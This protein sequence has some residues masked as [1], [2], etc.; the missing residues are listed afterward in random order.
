MPLSLIEADDKLAKISEDFKVSVLAALRDGE[1]KDLIVND[2]LLLII[3][4]RLYNKIK[5]RKGK[6]MEAIKVVRAD[7]WRLGNLCRLFLQHGAEQIH[8]SVLDMFVHQNFE[9]L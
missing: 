4:N 9:V 6:E 2:E 3:G 1:V 5:H 8:G 7:L